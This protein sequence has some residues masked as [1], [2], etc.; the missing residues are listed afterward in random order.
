[1][2]QN[3]IDWHAL[4]E[5]ARTVFGIK[6]WRP[7]QRELLEAVLQGR[8]ALGILPTGGGKSLCFELA[9]LF[10]P[11]PVIVVTPLISLAEDQTDK[12]E[13][14]KVAATRIDSTL[15]AGE[16]RRAETAVEGGRLELIYVTP[17]R[18]HNREFLELARQAGRRAK[19]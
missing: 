16:L 11:R 10:L 13:V 19:G 17:E 2:T 5:R 9:S 14:A 7:G 18:L 15:S 3:P 4:A 6:S 8:D 1:M 12:L